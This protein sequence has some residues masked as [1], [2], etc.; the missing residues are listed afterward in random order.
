MNNETPVAYSG[1]HFLGDWT[2]FTSGIVQPSA[3]GESKTNVM[4]IQPESHGNV[5][6]LQTISSITQKSSTL[7]LA[8]GRRT[9]FCKGLLNAE[10]TGV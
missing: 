5:M 7:T 6:P 2:F 10:V 9:V 8:E 3:L 4:C 1:F